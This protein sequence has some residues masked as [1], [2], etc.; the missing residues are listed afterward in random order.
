MSPVPS[1]LASALRVV[2]VPAVAAFAL[3]GPPTASAA[4]SKIAYGCGPDLCVV[5][6]ESGTTAPVTTDGA[7]DPYAYPSLSADGTRL[8][9]L[10]GQDVVVGLTG[11]LTEVWETSRSI[12]GVALSP[13][14][15]AVLESH[16]YV[17]N[18]F[19]C[20]LTG[21]CLVLVDK[22]GASWSRG[23]DGAG[24]FRRLKGG[25]G[26]GWLGTAV[27][28][29]F[30]TRGDDRHTVCATDDPAPEDPVCRPVATEVGTSLTDP[31]GSSD[32]KLV[33]GV[34]GTAG[35]PSQVV[36][37]DAATTAAVRV[38]AEGASPTFS[39]DAKQVAYRDTAGGISIVPT[40]GGKA[41]RVVPA[42]TSPSW[43][44]GAAP[45]STVRGE[46]TSAKGASV[47]SSS[48][49]YRKR[50]IPVSVRCTGGATCRGTLR[51]KKG[52]T[53][54]G[55]RSYTVKAGKRATVTVSPTRAGRRSLARSKKH[56]VVVRLEAKGGGA[57]TRKATVR[58]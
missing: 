47:V 2:A 33:V 4:P 26:V 40:A 3:A 23:V 43:S 21:G 53:V 34:R 10:R 13:D 14:G 46:G 45:G 27:L 9:A 15:A 20:P 36:V 38:L 48:L 5:D 30:Y 58:R 54:L 39:P 44:G 8:A 7:A 42:G 50:R 52:T 1:R 17:Q 29:S 51:I 32:G 35:A 25:G 37:Y 18:E 22:S 11:N 55:S 49:R 31:D 24:G 6:P 41:R 57:V 19:G 16:S 56:A 12:N 28:S